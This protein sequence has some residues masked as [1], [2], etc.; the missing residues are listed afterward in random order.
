MNATLLL[1]L[2]C[3]QSPTVH[4]A[5]ITTGHYP[6]RIRNQFH[7]PLFANRSL[8]TNAHIMIMHTHTHKHTHISRVQ[9]I[10]CHTIN[11]QKCHT[12]C[13]YIDDDE[14]CIRR[15]TYYT[16]ISLSLVRIIWTLFIRKYSLV[17]FILIATQI[18]GLRTD[19]AHLISES[20][21]QLCTNKGTY[22]QKLWLIAAQ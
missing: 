15:N 4:E 8:F 1:A 20:I 19:S 11:K 22:K 9:W 17:R 16:S 7:C 14:V 5:A 6:F 21:D 13:H 18:D 10:I 3:M 2:V 12:E